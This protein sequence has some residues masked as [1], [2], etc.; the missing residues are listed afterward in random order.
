MRK[1]PMLIAILALSGLILCA[2]QS[3][4]A[5][6]KANT[7]TPANSNAATAN[8][9]ADPK[10]VEEVKEMLARHDKALNDKNIDAVMATF[11]N[12]PKTV[13]LGTGQGERF[14][15]QQAIKE[16]YMEIF[17]DY[18]AGTLETNCDWK[19]GGADEDGKMAWLAATCQAKDAM[20]GV[21]REYGLNVSAAVVKQ[22]GGWRFVM[23]HMS[24]ATASGPPPNATDKKG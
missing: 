15:G 22:D 9:T 17:K 12:D 14:V 23:L 21:K 24:N 2:C 10:V 6:T 16:A 13:V 11:S 1:R 4:Q 8:S 20:K 7:N 18:D 3:Q 5:D 19:T